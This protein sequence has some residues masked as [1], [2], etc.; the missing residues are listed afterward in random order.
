MR[1]RDAQFDNH[2]LGA[3][4]PVVLAPARAV[5]AP[6]PP[7]YG[8]VAWTAGA[9]RRT[10]AGGSGADGAVGGAAMD[11]HGSRPQLPL[12]EREVR[13]ASDDE[14]APTDDG[15]ASDDASDDATA[16]DD[17]MDL[18][19]VSVRILPVAPNIDRTTL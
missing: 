18:K 5:C 11:P 19:Y 16:A 15:A 8:G 14:A 13:I 7:S 3:A 1:V 4:Y 10:G 6:T 2:C 17:V 9:A 12:F